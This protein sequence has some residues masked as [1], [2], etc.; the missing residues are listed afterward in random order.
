MRGD[1]QPLL[2]VVI[3]CYN[4]ERRLGRSL[5]RILEYLEQSGWSWE[6]IVVDDGSSDGTVTLV[7][8][9][10]PMAKVLSHHPNRGKGYAVQQ[11]MLAAGGQW[12]LFTDSDLATPIEHLG[13]FMPVAQQG[14]PVVIGSRKMRGA[15]IEHAQPWLRRHLAKGFALLS[16]LMLG[17]RLADTTCGFKL[18]SREAA[19]AIFSRQTI[20]DW[21]FDSENMAV[22]RLLGYRVRELPVRWCDSP[23]TKVRLLRDTIKSFLGLLVIRRNIWAGRYRQPGEPA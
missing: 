15:V 3:P 11:G 21:T 13:E 17:T 4:E 2:S 8:E 1:E 18:F 6:L 22:A 14:V 12:V 5:R 20:H 10:A 23:A 16:N 9:L 7:R 19:Q